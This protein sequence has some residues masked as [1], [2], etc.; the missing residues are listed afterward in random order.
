MVNISIPLIKSC[1]ID[2]PNFGSP[3]NEAMKCSLYITH[4]NEFV[5][6]EPAASQKVHHS[7]SYL[8]KPATDFRVLI[9]SC[10]I[11]LVRVN[12]KLQVVFI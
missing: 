5:I 9:A 2:C 10:N 1:L 7:C 12:F 3:E 11:L 6:P 4:M 8:Q